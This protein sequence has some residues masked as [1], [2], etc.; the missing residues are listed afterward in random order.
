MSD[1]VIYSNI[2]VSNEINVGLEFKNEIIA[3]NLSSSNTI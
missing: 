1:S 2:V 3:H